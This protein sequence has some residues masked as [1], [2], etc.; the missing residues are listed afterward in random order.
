MPAGGSGG[1]SGS[2]GGGGGPGGGGPLP[3][4]ELATTPERAIVTQY[5]GCTGCAGQTVDTTV[6]LK[7]L[8]TATLKVT[9]VALTP[10]T[11]VPASWKL[12][13]P[14]GELFSIDAG[15]EATVT[16]KVPRDDTSYVTGVLTIVSNA[17]GSPHGIS[18]AGALAKPMLTPS[19]VRIEHSATQNVEELWI[20]N[21]FTLP[22]GVTAYE[23]RCMTY[24]QHPRTCAG[25]GLTTTATQTVGAGGSI[26]LGTFSWQVG[27]DATRVQVF[28]RGDRWSDQKLVVADQQLNG[29]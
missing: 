3:A 1:G 20:K 21:D 10:E 24:D 14:Q 15:T 22:V 26:K 7:N 12:E 28:I 4:P 27:T 18:V 19:W 2:A 16:L 29:A 17:P 25:P 9:R 23:V 11:Q 8:G 5:T 6:R 13:L